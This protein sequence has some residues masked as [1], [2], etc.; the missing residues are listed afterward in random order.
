MINTLALYKEPNHIT[1]VEDI[2]FGISDLKDY[3]FAHSKEVIDPK[4]PI[5]Y[6][7]PRPASLDP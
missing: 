4:Q 7:P 1:K 5:P 3:Y 2:L 6:D